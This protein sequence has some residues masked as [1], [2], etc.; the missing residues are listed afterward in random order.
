MSGSFVPSSLTEILR[1][2]FLSEQS[3][4]LALS[5][6]EVR[7]RIHFDRGMIFFA[8]SSLEDEGLID[9]MVREKC[10]EMAEAARV[11]G[12][13]G[14]DLAL[15]RRLRETEAVSEEK[16]Q[17]G[18]RQLIQQVLIS[19]FRWDSGEYSFQETPPGGADA[20]P[21]DVM[22][23]FEY[24]MRGIRSM[25]GFAPIREAMLRLD[26][27]LRTS[28][29]LYLPLDRLTLHPIQGFALSRVDGSSRIRE[30]A[31]LIPPSEEDGAL[32]FLFG[33]LLLG[34]IEMTPPLSPGALSVRD[35]LEGDRELKERSERE[36]AVI[37]EMYRAVSATSP[38]DVLG[39]PPSSP[40]EAIQKAFEARRDAFRPERF[41]K[42]NLDAYRE[43]LMLIEG[44]L[45]EA[46]LALGQDRMREAA[47]GS[48]GDTKLDM[49]TMSKRKELTKTQ[50]QEIQ[51]EQIRR[52]EQ[53]YLKARE[54]FKRKDYYNVIQYCEQALRAHD[55]DARFHFLLGQA[56]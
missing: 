22:V 40:P 11:P 54:Y 39:L 52:A 46:Y 37:K 1:D 8:D 9:V 13:R 34:I 29:N 35:L 33:L 24:L 55:A 27:A 53:F 3:G 32:R 17:H 49:D 21:S 19:V 56:L 14:D 26:R 51:E 47:Q 2:L 28:D 12:G 38:W 30:I 31:S 6:T 10:L 48:T 18:I 23:T 20:F 5:R 25:A 36:S 16:L 41:M 42:K 50:V 15:G 43:E 4:V 44:R 7:K 45:L